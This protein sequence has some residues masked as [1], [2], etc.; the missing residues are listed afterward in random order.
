MSPP[1]LLPPDAIGALEDPAGEP[2][3][4]DEGDKFLLEEVEVHVAL[5]AKTL[6]GVDGVDVLVVA[7]VGVPDPHKENLQHAALGRHLVE[8]VLH[9]PSSPEGRLTVQEQVLTVVHDLNLVLLESVVEVGGRIV[10]A[11]FARIS[12]DVGGDACLANDV[13]S[14][15]VE[16]REYL[17]DVLTAAEDLVLAEHPGGVIEKS[18][19]G[20]GGVF[21]AEQ[22]SC[23]GVGR[24]VVEKDSLDPGEVAVVATQVEG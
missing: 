11:H 2:L 16:R 1:R 15:G 13:V 10:E 7:V 24:A 21:G 3:L 8:G 17:H 22:G 5:A 20:N 9:L 23:P 12:K 18:L 14:G 6:L 19:D 4:L